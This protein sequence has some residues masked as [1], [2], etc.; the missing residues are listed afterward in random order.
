[1]PGD[2]LV[3]REPGGDLVVVGAGGFGRETVEAV[4]AANEAGAGWHL[5]GYLDD[6][7]SLA[8]TLIDGTRVLG[9]IGELVNMPAVSVV[10]CTGRPDNYFSRPRLVR[11]LDLPLERY[12]TIIHPSAT[13]SSTSHV[14]AGSV[15]LGHVDLTASVEI[16]AHVAVM[17]H[18]TLTHDDVIE[19]YATLA[20]GIR[21]GGRVRIGRC[22]Y[23]GAAAMVREDRRVGDY[24]LVGMGAVVTRDI[25]PREV[26]I[27]IPAR[28]LRG[29]DIPDV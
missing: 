29:T 15:L 18:A 22:A 28:R 12:A 10:V 20:S 17:P 24:S 21:L 5:L 4:R 16:G 27:G 9:G 1:M 3:T 6:D 23:I 2:G 13:I 14:G 26:W 11:K 7:M 25:P 8:G 19:D